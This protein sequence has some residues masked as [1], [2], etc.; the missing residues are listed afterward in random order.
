MKSVSS[1]VLISC[2]PWKKKNYDSNI[3]YFTIRLS[4][5]RKFHVTFI[6][7]LYIFR[8]ILKSQVA[9]CTH[10]TINTLKTPCFMARDIIKKNVSWWKQGAPMT[11]N[12]LPW[13][14]MHSL[15]NFRQTQIGIRW[16]Y[17]NMLCSLI[18]LIEMDRL[19]TKI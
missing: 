11:S 5:K 4:T 19:S 12:L 10:P 15:F 8:I 7:L 9:S 16:K 13:S 6:G 2:F 3:C 18:R 14:L 1:V 17:I